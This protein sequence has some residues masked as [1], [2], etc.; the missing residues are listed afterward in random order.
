MGDS[1]LSSAGALIYCTSTH[2]YLFL[3]RNG[4]RHGSC[5]GLVG[6]KVEDN[7]TVI[8][9]LNRE[10]TE[11]IGLDLSQNK[12]IPVEKFTSENSKFNYHTFVI[13]VEEEFVPKLN[14]EHRG[15]CWVGLKDYPR[16][17]HPG[18]WRTF[19]FNVIID[20]IK[21]LESVL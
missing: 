14:S 7:E 9:G 3:L 19:N 11:E 13:S 8:E 2:R 15:Y 17:L 6:G 12:F 21:T 10:I 16:P 18:V 20:K 4:S 1:N 5:W